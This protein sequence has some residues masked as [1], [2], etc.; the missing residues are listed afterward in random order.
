MKLLS[1]AQDRSEVGEE[2]ADA[3][4]RPADVNA[5][6]GPLHE[7]TTAVFRTHI[8]LAAADLATSELMLRFGRIDDEGRVYV[9]GQPAG[10]SHNWRATPSFNI[11]K[12]L[13]PGDNSIAVVVQ[14][15]DGDGGINNG[16]SLTVPGRPMEPHWKRSVFNGLA[17][18]IVQAG[19]QPGEI[20]LTARAQDL[21]IGTIVLQVSGHE[22]SPQ[23]A[24]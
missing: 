12:F 18:I 6:S 3:D 23:A 19:T 20:R 4:W 10:E 24:P 7:N 2:V 1:S 21:T 22:P 17:Q 15:K 5:D 14:N 16:V 8:S 11:R 13:H 9:N